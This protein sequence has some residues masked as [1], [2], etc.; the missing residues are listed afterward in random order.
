M[1]VFIYSHLIDTLVDKLSNSCHRPLPLCLCRFHY[2]YHDFAF[3]F[4]SLF[5]RFNEFSFQKL[6]RVWENWV[7]SPSCDKRQSELSVS[8]RIDLFANLDRQMSW[9]HCSNLNGKTGPIYAMLARKNKTENG[10]ANV[11]I[12]NFDLVVANW[13]S[14]IGS[15]LSRSNRLVGKRVSGW[16]LTDSPVT[17]NAAS[18]IDCCQLRFAGRV[19]YFRTCPQSCRLNAVCAGHLVTAGSQLRGLMIASDVMNARHIFYDCPHSYWYWGGECVRVICLAFASQQRIN[20]RCVIT[21]RR[22]KRDIMR[23]W[24][25]IVI[26][27]CD[28]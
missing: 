18:D 26:L 21:H 12:S 5:D 9:N 6:V 10:P 28:E 22:G 3:V 4:S 8:S 14:T 7:P 17:W 16:T 2:V 24:L 20:L 13:W 23:M 15:E 11:G 1:Y 19:E 27:K 25:K